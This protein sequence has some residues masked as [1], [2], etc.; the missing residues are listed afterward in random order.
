MKTKGNGMLRLFCTVLCFAVLMG[1]T[2][3]TAMAATQYGYTMFVQVKV[4]G[5]IDTSGTAE[6]RLRKASD[7]SSYRKL[8]VWSGDTYY[9]AFTDADLKWMTKGD[10]ILEQVSAPSGAYLGA[11]RTWPVK[12]TNVQYK[13]FRPDGAP[14]GVG[15]M[16]FLVVDY[17]LGGKKYTFNPKNSAAQMAY[18]VTN[19]TVPVA[20]ASGSGT[21]DVPKTGDNSHLAMWA[22]LMVCSAAGIALALRRN[23]RY[24]N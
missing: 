22:L 17:T 13:E 12:I 1:M 5:Q 18:I 7:A 11:V 4:D 14:A 3:A 24:E 6:F 19:S 21:W 23:G 9:L 15:S 8:N 16:Y 20:A 10:Y 2:A